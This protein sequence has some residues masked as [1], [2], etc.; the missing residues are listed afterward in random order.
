MFDD[1]YFIITQPRQDDVRHDLLPDL[2]PDEDTAA[3]N[4]RYEALPLGSKPLK[5]RNSAKSFRDRRG[6]T[7]MKVPPDVLF[8]GDNPVVRSRI[9]DKLL[10]LNIPHLAIQPAIYLDDW[11]TW[12]EDYW[13]LTFLET[14]HCWDPKKSELG[15]RVKAVDEYLYTMYRVSLDEAVMRSTPLEQRLLFQLDTLPGLVLAHRSVAGFFRGGG[16]SGALVV[17]LQDYPSRA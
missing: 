14:F 1:E 12:H 9:R 17:S 3:L 4:F 10:A 6:M 16:S 5:F 15:E 11:G 7:T 8:D 13:Y 2:G